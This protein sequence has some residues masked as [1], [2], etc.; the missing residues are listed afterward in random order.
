M[1]YHDE[2]QVLIGGFLLS[3]VYRTR[4]LVFIKKTYSRICMFML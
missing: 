4:Y 2:G 1:F 3:P